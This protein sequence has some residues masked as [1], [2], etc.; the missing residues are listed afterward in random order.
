MAKVT[1][2]AKPAPRKAVGTAPAAPPRANGG[3]KPAA[4]ATRQHQDRSL[5]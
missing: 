3:A 4:A 5:R 2:P 1:K